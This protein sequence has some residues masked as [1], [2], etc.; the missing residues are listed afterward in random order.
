MRESKMHFEQIPVE[1]VKK[2]AYEFHDKEFHDKEFHDEELNDDVAGNHNPL[3]EA[4][5]SKLRP[6]RSASLRTQRPA[7]LTMQLPQHGIN[8][9]ICGKPVALETAK[10]DEAGHAAHGE[11]YLLKLGIDADRN[12]G[13]ASKQVQRGT[14]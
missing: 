14:P 6:Q 2:I 9:S 10:T 13:Q 12:S 8:C 5:P 11:C 3:T 1:V 4:S 7:V